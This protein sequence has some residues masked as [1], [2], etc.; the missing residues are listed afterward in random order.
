M[1]DCDVCAYAQV[2]GAW[3][4]EHK[5]THCR[6]C[7][8]SWAG[9]AEAHCVTCHEHFS[10]NA[11][12]DLHRA[13]GRCHNPARMH[14]KNEHPLFHPKWGPFGLTWVPWRSPEDPSS[15]DESPDLE[16]VG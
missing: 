9:R 3:P 15:A 16:D 8:R 12:A 10:S 14:R 6:E 7:H 5:A 1:G 13:G 2:H 4:P 11:T